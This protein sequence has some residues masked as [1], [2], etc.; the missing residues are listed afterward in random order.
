M[1]FLNDD[2]GTW[3][4]FTLRDGRQISGTIVHPGTV[5]LTT[6]EPIVLCVE[7]HVG[8]RQVFIPWC[9]VST[10]YKR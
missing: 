7:A 3:Y 6:G 10:Y 9:V 5:Y 1:N 8:A 2:P 4:E